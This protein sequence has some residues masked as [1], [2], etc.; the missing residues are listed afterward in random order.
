MIDNSLKHEKTLEGIYLF[1]SQKDFFI[2]ERITYS[3]TAKTSKLITDLNENENFIENEIE[4]FH[5]NE[6]KESEFIQKYRFEP[7]KR[8]KFKRFESIG[9]MPNNEEKK[10][11]LKKMK[12]K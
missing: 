12:L 6:L 1:I 4:H 5:E 2:T 3:E 8:S 10:T 9:E 7:N 11:S